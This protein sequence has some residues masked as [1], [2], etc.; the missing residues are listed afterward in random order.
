MHSD[1][2]T[3][4]SAVNLSPADAAGSCFLNYAGRPASFSACIQCGTC[5]NVCPVVADYQQDPQL[6]GYLDLTPQQI[7]NT[8]RLGITDRVLNSKMAW[9]CFMCFKC[10]E[11]CP[12]HIPVAEM[13]YELRNRGYREIKE[14]FK[15]SEV[16]VRR[17]MVLAKFEP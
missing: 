7:V 3:C 17:L 15:G 10:Q 14:P 11:H 9:D 13:M 2:R 12:K 6:L 1:S 16:G 4:K 5:T 8:Y